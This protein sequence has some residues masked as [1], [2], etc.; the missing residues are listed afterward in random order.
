VMHFISCGG[1][2]NCH[3][4]APSYCE[5]MFERNFGATR[6]DGSSGTRLTDGT[7]LHSHFFGQSSFA[8]HVLANRRN[9]VRVPSGLTLALLAPFGCGV[10]TGAGAVLNALRPA[11]GS[12]LAVFGAGSVGLSAVL[13]ARLAGCTT[14]VAIDLNPARLD[15]ALELGA[16]HVVESGDA[17][18]EAVRDIV[19]GGVDHT[20][21]ATARPEVLRAA[22]DVLA[23][24]GSC[25]VIGGPALGTEVSL[26]VNTVLLGRTVRGVVQGDSVPSS[27]IPALIELYRQGRFPVDRLIRTYPF[28]AIEQAVE[29]AHSGVTVKPVLEM[30]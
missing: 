3:R 8:T 23:V 5:T 4:G 25:A 2:R 9:V 16:T 28:A 29:D 7:P 13:A 21:E 17:T 27:F 22:V 26:D 19:A 24:R 12:S 20:I 15:L 18:V 6:P 11:V 30:A 1:C 14:I 10:Q